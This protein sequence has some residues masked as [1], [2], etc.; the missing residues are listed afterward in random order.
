MLFFAALLA[1]VPSQA[2]TRVDVSPVPRWIVPVAMPSGEPTDGAISIRLVDVQN[3]VDV[4]GVHQTYRQVIKVLS[5]EGLAIAGT[6][7]VAWQPG[8][9]MARVH[10]VT[11]R[12]G[13]RS[14]DVLKDGS[15]FQLLRRETNLESA[16]IDGIVTAVLSIPDLRVG[17]EVEL[18]WTLDSSNPTLKGKVENDYALFPGV[19]FGRLFMRYSWPIDRQV[20]YRIGEN[21]PPGRLW[22]LGGERGFQI[23]RD[24]FRA[25]EIP[26]GAPTRFADRNRIVI[27]DFPDWQSVSELMR[28]L[29]DD[30][31]RVDPSGGV[32][33][34]IKRIGAM[35]DDPKFRA[36]EA[37][38]VVQRQVRYFARGDGLG[39]YKPQPADEVWNSRAG[40]CKGKTVLL[41]AMLRGLGLKADA[42]IVSANRG[43]GL[44]SALPMPGRFDHVIVRVQMADVTYWLDGTRIG[45][46]SVETAEVPPY[47]WALPMIAGKTALV[48]LSPREPSLADD[49]YRLDLDARSGIEKPAKA[50]ASAIFRRESA[51]YLRSLL[52][53]MPQEKRE[54]FLRKIWSDRHTWIT[55]DKVASDYNE[56]TGELTFSMSGVGQMDWNTTGAAPLR[57]YEAN[58]ARMGQSLTPERSEALKN[59]APVAVDRRY[60]VVRQTIFLPETMHGFRISGD[61]I[62]TAIGGI[63]YKRTAT[64]KD[65]RFDMYAETQSAAGELTYAD[66]KIADGKT[67]DLFQKQLFIRLPPVTSAKLPRRSE[68]NAKAVQLAG[69]ISDADYPKD[70]IAANQSGTTVVNFDIEPDGRVAVCRIGGSSGSAALDEA[71]CR[72]VSE[73]FV[74]QPATDSKGRPKL[75]TRTQRITWR[76]PNMPRNIEAFD[77]G[78]S[79]TI[80]AQGF[81]REC[82]IT[83]GAPNEAAAAAFCKSIDGIKLTGEGEEGSAVRVT[84]HHVR[85]VQSVGTVAKA[86]VP[87]SSG[88]PR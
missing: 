19:N 17:D 10:A 80:D 3:H 12:R 48:A 23:E 67:D 63:Y 9:S 40:D 64:L 43:D 32:A 41:V 58:K 13:G 74:F 47:R 11:V 51:S 59:A 53:V 44:N 72:I 7:T 35:S 31:A 37:L 33:A 61:Q 26:T 75:E 4:G 8:T 42:A 45:D 30:A 38:K 79:Y 66:A 29:Y 39:G 78:L 50:K 1:A 34:E 54:E 28:P 52:V 84:E 20:G 55:I 25:P 69:S 77:Y 5:P 81:G 22:A 86:P 36:S 56:D 6:V 68:H 18:S 62:D 24:G 57:Q 73:R 87:A 70:A 83:S 49:E 88:N 71:S 65:G 82:A 85:K 60:S 76:M 15:A 2:Q 21:L 14:I 16:Q 46:R 27:S